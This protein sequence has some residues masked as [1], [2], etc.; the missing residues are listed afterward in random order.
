MVGAKP[1]SGV[2]VRPQV[3]T[4]ARRKRCINSVS[5]GGT[6]APLTN[7]LPMSQGTPFIRRK[8]SFTR[9]GTP[10]KGASASFRSIC[11]FQSG[12]VAITALICG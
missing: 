6:N 12:S 3:T 1:T 11:D 7:R 8:R 4:P 9:N 5:M 10:K 2:L